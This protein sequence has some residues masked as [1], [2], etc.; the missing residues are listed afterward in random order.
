M[1]CLVG[2]RARGSARLAPLLGV[3]LA[4]LAAGAPA[5]QPAP[6]PVATAAPAAAAAKGWW[7][8]PKVVT[9]LGLTEAQRSALDAADRG[10]REERTAAMKGYSKAYAAF[11]AVLT[12]DAPDGEAVARERA[13]LVAA[14]SELGRVN[15]DRLVA[16]RGILSKAQMEQLPKAAPAALRAGPLTLRGFGD[17]GAAASPGR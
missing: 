9:Q 5:Q 12:G 14:W 13:A 3:A 2:A 15:A 11:L 4:F 16:V 1:S 8:Q 6:T 10:Y 17:V 7:N